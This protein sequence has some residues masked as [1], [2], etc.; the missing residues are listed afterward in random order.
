MKTNNLIS[1][2]GKKPKVSS[3]AFVADNATIIGDVEIGSESSIWFNV[4]LRG[5]VN[6]IRVGSKT[7]IQ[8]GTI[9]HVSSTDYPTIIGTGVLIGH[10]ATIHACTLED[11]SFI[12]MSATVM[13]GSVV[14]NGSMV[15]AGSLILPKTRVKSGQLWAGSPA[16]FL[17]KISE[18]EISDF[19]HYIKTYISLGKKYKKLQSP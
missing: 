7:N 3:D 6:F 5:D 19:S 9:V 16:K 13:D 15:A 1:W 4:V 14:E 2:S 8:D 11:G 10:M 17:R 18:S 12:G